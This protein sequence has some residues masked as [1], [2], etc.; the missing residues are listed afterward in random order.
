MEVEVEGDR[1][2]IPRNTGPQVGLRLAG[3]CHHFDE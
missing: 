3:Y 1:A 2:Q